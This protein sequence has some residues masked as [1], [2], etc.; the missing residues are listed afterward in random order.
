MYVLIKVLISPSEFNVE[1]VVEV[2]QISDSPIA[3]GNDNSFVL[4]KS[5]DGV[6]V[7][8]GQTKRNND[9][10]C[11]ACIFRDIFKKSGELHTRI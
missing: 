8:A 1:R 5:T 3:H 11:E 2:I 7:V 9:Y 6:H 4:V 10:C